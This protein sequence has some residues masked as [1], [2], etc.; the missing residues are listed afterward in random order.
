MPGAAAEYAGQALQVFPLVPRTKRPATSH[1]FLDATDDPDQVS[2]WWRRNPEYNIGVRPPS[3][4]VVIDVDPQNGGD[5]ALAKLVQ[6][7]GPLPP[8]LTALTGGGGK[9]LWFKIDHPGP[10]QSPCPGVD[11]KVGA[12]GFVV[13]APS[14]HP[15]GNPYVWDSSCPSEPVEC[16]NRLAQLLIKP[17][18]PEPAPVRLVIGTRIEPTGLDDPWVRKIWDDEL[19]DLASCP[20][21]GGKW[22]GRNKHANN[23]TLTL[24]RLP[25]LTESQVRQAVIDAC[26]FN[27]LIADKGLPALEATMNSAQRKAQQEGPR[28][29]PE[30]PP[31]SPACT[32]EASDAVAVDPRERAVQIELDKL[33]VR[34]DARR[35]FEAETRPLSAFPPVT[36]LDEFLAQP[37]SPTA[38]RIDRIAPVGG[39]VVLAAQFK[40]GKTTLIGNAIR[41][42]ADGEPFLGAFDVKIPASRIV[43]VDDELDADMQR[44]WLRAQGIRNTAA[45]ADVVTLRGKT[46]SFDILDDAIRDRWAQ[47][48]RDLGA[49]YLILDCLRPVM[50]AL[51]LDENHDA[52]KFLAAFD[53]LLADAG[54]RDATVVHHMGHH[55][56]R[57]RGDSRL[58]DWPDALWRLVRENDEP[59]S[60]RFFS[61]FG[62]DVSVPEGRLAF[63]EVTR[64]LTYVS[65]SRSDAKMETA[66]V[67]V[68]EHLA[69]MA[70]DGSNGGVSKRQIEDELSA[71]HPQKAIREALKCVVRRGLVD[72][73]PGERRAQ[74]LRIARPCSE[75][76]FPVAGQGQ[77]HES[78]RSEADKWALS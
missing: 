20:K 48:W 69:G 24:L 19:A 45:V 70:R 66:V 16:P 63:D 2:D 15:N 18:R 65:G 8:T 49:D 72:S 56:E 25:G 59:S 31:I 1:G 10:F 53:A 41:S 46:A 57:A 11:V 26:T 73:A 33:R 67:A 64:R 74:L 6:Q 50:D 30:R 3:G 9:H 22:D 14:V 23:T 34:A 62:R 68:I 4:I 5:V 52:G 44:R 12:T 21:G 76:G 47:R 13:A 32:I 55:G 29:K 54:V 71:A 61:A 37:D 75:C 78:C 51:G 58:L 7:H 77:R 43:V 27:G 36:P 17:P 35:R 38:Y 28:E 42:L 60:A 39:R 40:A